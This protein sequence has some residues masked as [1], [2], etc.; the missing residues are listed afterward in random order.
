MT[1]LEIPFDLGETVYIIKKEAEYIK[2]YVPE[3]SY[4]IGVDWVREPAHYE[5]TVKFNRVIKQVPFKFGLLDNYKI[6]EI[7]KNKK[8]AEKHLEILE[9]KGQ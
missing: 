3:L 4:N 6:D 5:T 8:D 9:I 1:R 7:Y 2:E